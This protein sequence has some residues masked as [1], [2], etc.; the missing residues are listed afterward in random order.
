MSSIRRRS[1][2]APS[3][4][5][6]AT[7]FVFHPGTGA[8]TTANFNPQAD[9][10]EL[11]N[12]NNIHSV[13]QLAALITTDAQGDAVIGLGHHDSITLPGVSAN[14]L[15]AHLHSLVHLG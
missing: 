8:E 12:F 15:Q 9:T 13:H 2:L 3:F 10:I 1:P 5:R 11:D 4:R 7:T 14:Y 6:T